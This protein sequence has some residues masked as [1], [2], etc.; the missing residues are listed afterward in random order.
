MRIAFIGNVEFSR[1]ALEKL[2]AMDAG[3]AGVLTR[4]SSALNSDHFDLGPIAAAKAVPV[5]YQED[6]DTDATSAWLAGLAPDVVFCFGWSRLLPPSILS[7]PPL[8]VVGFHPAP[9][10]RGRGRHPIIWA[11]ALGLEETA[12]T[13]FLMDEGADT[14]PILSQTAISIIP[15]DDAASLYD[16]IC[17]T[18]IGQI[19][20]FVPAMSR[21]EIRPV[22]QDGSTATQWRKRGKFDGRIDWRMPARSVA[23]LVRAL[24]R[25]YPGAHFETREG[26]EVLVWKARVLDANPDPFLVPGSVLDCAPDASWFDVRCADKPIRIL[27]HQGDFT[28]RAGDWLP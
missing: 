26:S 1:R 19:A 8:G 16:K 27:S 28:P 11:L 4:R 3:I 24:A 6:L 18:A 2:L 5:A 25:P 20:D 7:I 21:G 12:S 13:F 22:P 14:G 10:P 23:N 9:L 17:S 15:S